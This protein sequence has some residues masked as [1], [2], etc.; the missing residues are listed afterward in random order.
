MAAKRPK[1]SP[2]SNQ[3]FTKTVLV[4]SSIDLLFLIDPLHLNLSQSQIRCN[5]L[6]SSTVA[7]PYGG[8]SPYGTIQYLNT[9]DQRLFQG[10]SV[11]IPAG[12]YSVSMS[13]AHSCPVTEI[14]TVTQP[15]MMRRRFGGGGGGANEKSGVRDGRKG[16]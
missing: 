8:T 3:V 1:L 6:N 7:S 10:S 15:G 2:F 11:N 13:D 9:A 14:I 4:F 12:T 5:G 16:E